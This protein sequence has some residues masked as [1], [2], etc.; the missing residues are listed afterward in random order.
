MGFTTSRDF[1][2][3][4]PLPFPSK[5]VSDTPFNNQ[6]KKVTPLP[7][8]TNPIHVEE[9]I[10]IRPV[11]EDFKPMPIVEDFRPMPVVEDFKPLPL[12][13]D[14]KP[15]PIIKDFLPTPKDE[16]APDEPLVFEGDNKLTTEISNLS[17]TGNG[18][19]ID[20][21]IAA[22][23][24]AGMG[25]TLLIIGSIALAG[26]GISKLVKKSEKTTTMSGTSSSKSSKKSK[27]K[28]KKES[29]AT[30]K[31]NTKQTIEI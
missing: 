27:T 7:I 20:E 10:P 11:I 14:I 29:K 23:K 26:Y 9:F 1:A 18:D 24:T 30:R 31:G 6:V 25:K 17:V 15:K 28:S 13:E 5:P 4:D 2:L 21:S 3:V 16:K 12:V 22:P 8:R 19:I